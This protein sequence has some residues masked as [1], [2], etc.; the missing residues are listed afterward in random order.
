MSISGT[1]PA[2]ERGVV[3]EVRVSGTN[4]TEYV[5]W[6]S[7]ALHVLNNLPEIGEYIPDTEVYALNEWSYS[8]SQNAF[9]DKDD[10]L[11]YTVSLNNSQTFPTDFI[12]QNMEF[13]AI[14]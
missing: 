4:Q 5:A 1:L 6:V 8:I 3:H 2:E 14:F 12:F 9:I 10:E 13:W 11:T 7:F